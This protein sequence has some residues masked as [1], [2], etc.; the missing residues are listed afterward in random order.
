MP[1]EMMTM[2]CCSH[3]IDDL[4]YIEFIGFCFIFALNE[5]AQMYGT[6]CIHDEIPDG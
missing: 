2:N 6:I 5:C 3:L 4:F 1:L